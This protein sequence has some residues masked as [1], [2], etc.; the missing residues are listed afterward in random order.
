MSL[1]PGDL[2]NNL[3]SVDS[4]LMQQVTLADHEQRVRENYFQKTRASFYAN[5]IADSLKVNSL[6]ESVDSLK[7]SMRFL[8]E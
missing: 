3:N 8:S 5:Y 7:E 4:A 1:D 6:K 2:K